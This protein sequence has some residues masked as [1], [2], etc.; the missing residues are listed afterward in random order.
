VVL[1]KLGL[2]A[3][4]VVLAVAGTACSSSGS[5]VPTSPPNTPTPTAPGASSA[6]TPTGTVSPGTSVS[7]PESANGA[8]TTTAGTL[9]DTPLAASAS[10]TCRYLTQDIVNRILPGATYSAK[11]SGDSDGLG[12]CV[13]RNTVTGG[14][15]QL[16]EATPAWLKL[17]S[18]TPKSYAGQ[19]AASQVGADSPYVTHPDGIGTYAVE[20][21]VT[22]GPVAGQKSIGWVQKSEGWSIEVYSPKTRP[23]LLQAVARAISERI[24]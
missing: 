14:Q 15:V 2:V 12:L 24:G 11:G 1:K 3:A 5:D 16:S 19:D 22:T 13:Y 10:G 17:E 20:I 6:S 18:A 4:A 23:E 8:P 9:K 7:Q 21:Y